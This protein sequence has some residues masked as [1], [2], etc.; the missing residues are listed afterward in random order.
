MAYR[1]P[2]KRT[3]LKEDFPA[4][5]N[6]TLS[7]ND[8]PALSGEKPVVAKPVEA[9]ETKPTEA[10]EAKPK[11]SFA[12]LFK[13]VEKK[14]Q[15]KKMKWGLVKL[16]KKG[17]EDSLT[18]EEREEEARWQ[19]EVAHDAHVWKLFCR[20]DKQHEDLKAFDP[21]Y[22]SPDELTVSSSEEEEKEKEEEVFSDEYEEDEFEPEI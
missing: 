5:S 12:S 18:P 6:A 21:L 4:L 14:K 11:K 13:N 7:K 22:E 10:T 20:L 2:Q 1:P 9:K 17:M 3:P 16:T 15:K 19:E 8:F